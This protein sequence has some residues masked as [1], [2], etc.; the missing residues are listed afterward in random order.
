MMGTRAIY[1][2]LAEVVAERHERIRRDAPCEGCGTTLADCMSERGKD[3]TAPPWFG[4]C[5]C[6]TAMAPCAH[7]SDRAQLSE[8]LGEIERGS[9]RTVAEIDAEAEARRARLPRR[10]PGKPHGMAERFR[11]GEWWRTKEGEWVRIADMEASHRANTA[12]FLIRRAA[13]YAE[14]MGFSELVGMQGAPDEVVDEWIRD[15]SRRM[16]DPEKWMRSTPLY[17]ALTGGIEEES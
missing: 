7:R 2:A 1:Q 9:V 8:L 17:R 16:D 12:R 3:P 10:E 6:G 5:A 4:C 11:Q 15:D 13:G 14:A